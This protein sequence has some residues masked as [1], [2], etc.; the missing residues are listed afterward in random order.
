[1][2]SGR[3]EKDLQIRELLDEISYLRS[4]NLKLQ[5]RIDE[6]EDELTEARERIGNDSS[7][8]DK[9]RK[10]AGRK[11]NGEKWKARYDEIREAIKSGERP[12]DTI[13]RL[14]ISKPTYY[15]FRNALFSA[16]AAGGGE[17]ASPTE[18]EA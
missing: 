6:L 16:A 11:K 7:D 14:K 17:Q 10:K 13:R 2:E 12:V 18:E 8:P 9:V 15:R 5:M 4:R 3:D 1:M